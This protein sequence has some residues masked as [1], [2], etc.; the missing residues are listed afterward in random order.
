MFTSSLI[1]SYQVQIKQTTKA[2]ILTNNTHLS[3]IYFFIVQQHSMHCSAAICFSEDTTKPGP[4][5]AF[6]DVHPKRRRSS[7]NISFNERVRVQLIQ[8]KASGMTKEEKSR[9][10]YTK[11]DMVGFQ[12]ECKDICKH[13]VEKARTLS[14]SNPVMPHANSLSSILQSDA[15]LR[16]FE[17]QICPLRKSNKLMVHQAFHSYQKQLKA[18]ESTLSQQERE[19]LLA[20]AYSSLSQCSKS[21]ALLIAQKDSMAVSAAPCRSS[22]RY[23]T[24]PHAVS[25]VTV[26]DKRSIEY[27]AG[28][29]QRKRC[30]TSAAA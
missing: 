14:R 11:E 20:S 9:V 8:G 28:S 12:Q 16:G 26:G 7:K 3:T 27:A 5:S 2:T 22:S 4:R 24:I 25:P 23:N 21:M 1:S 17:A 18:L 10:C 30:R 19:M 6:R 15:N 13:A 29:A